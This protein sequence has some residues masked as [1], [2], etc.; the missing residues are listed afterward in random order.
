MEISEEKLFELAFNF[1]LKKMTN[2]DPANFINRVIQVKDTMKAT[3]EES[4][5]K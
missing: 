5:N 4:K 2:S 3:L 1:C